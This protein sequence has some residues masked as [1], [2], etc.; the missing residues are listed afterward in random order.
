[1]KPSIDASKMPE[2]HDAKLVTLETSG[3]KPSDSVS[4]A[5]SINQFGFDLYKQLC[6]KD[7][8]VIISPYSIS[9]ALQLAYQGAAGETATEM[10]SVLH[11]GNDK[12]RLQ[13]VAFLQNVINKHEDNYVLYSPNALWI[14]KRSKFKNSYLQAVKTAFS[15]KVEAADFA[16]DAQYERIRINNWVLEQT[17]NMIK[18]LIPASGVNASTT[19]VLVNALY[20]EAKWDTAFEPKKTRENP[21][22]S[23]AGETKQVPMMVNNKLQYFA[24]TDP[25]GELPSTA[26]LPYKDDKYEMLVVMPK[27]GTIESFE[28][29]LTFERLVALKK[30]QTFGKGMLQIPKFTFDSDL[31]LKDNLIQLGMR[32]AFSAAD[33][34]NMTS[35]GIFISEVFHKAK[36]IVDESG[37][38]AAA[39]TAV[40]ATK[41]A[42]SD[43][44]HEFIADHPFLFFII[45]KS[46]GVILFMGKVVDPLT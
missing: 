43:M 14:D 39:A 41:S 9:I 4:A 7:G 31:K 30:R 25:K 45:E 28:K 26:T 35:E 27:L 44:N 17:K 13:R 12:N 18:D 33:F 40:V 3:L 5:T 8:N 24:F 1:V 23:R 38:K 19:A 15:S 46:T 42:G 10:N 22:E 11:L 6:A 37:T 34:S 29:E 2:S 21:F 36:V 32:R 20:F 16:H